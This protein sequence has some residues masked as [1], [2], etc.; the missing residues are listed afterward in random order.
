MAEQLIL[1][2][3]VGGVSKGLL[4]KG[5]TSTSPQASGGGRPAF[6]AKRTLHAKTEMRNSMSE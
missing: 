1:W 6:L 5:P 4:P 2:R 3:L